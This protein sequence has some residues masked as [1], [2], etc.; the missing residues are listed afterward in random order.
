MPRLPVPGSDDGTWGTVLNDYLS[1]EHNAD[2]T[3]KSTGSLAAKAN[4]STVVHL[5]GSETITGGKTFLVSPT[6]PSPTVG[7][8][9]ANKTYV[10]TT[11]AK[12]SSD[13]IYVEDYG[14]IGDGVTDDSAAITNAITTAVSAA[15]TNGSYYAEVRFQAKTYFVNTPTTGGTTNGS[16]MI[17]LPVILV[18]SQKVTLVLKGVGAA[19]GLYHW[20]QT[21]VQKAGS[22]LRT[23]Y[24]AGST[25]PATGEVSVLGGPTPHYGYGYPSG[26]FSNMLIVV[27]ALT[28]VVP[29]N[30]QICGFDFRGVAEMQ[31]KSAAALAAST[32]SGAPSI[33][34]PTW[35]WGISPP[36][37]QNNAI[38][39]I[40]SFNVEG[41]VSGLRITEHIRCSSLRAINC[42]N[43]ILCD[44]SSG[45][46]H[47]NIITYASVE[48]CT[49][50]IAS[51]SS[52]VKLNIACLDTESPTAATGDHQ[53]NDPGN[54]MV[55]TI[56]INAN[57]Y[58][59]NDLN[60]NILNDATLGVN[61]AS[62]LRII[63]S[64]M[65]PGAVTAPTVPAS[66]T[67]LKNPFW[68]DAA[69]SITG[70]V[71]A[72]KVDGTALGMNGTL[73][74]ATAYVPSGKTIELDY[75]GAAPAWNW[76]IL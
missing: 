60:T 6:V 25:V 34:V 26:L 4:D 38:C 13:A 48:N 64:E 22:V 19:N 32:H 15:Q 46:P 73:A 70:A 3:L 1:V 5:S 27:D 69:V 63:N 49:R 17:P 36:D 43:G 39:D 75:S 33:P 42:F 61:G 35:G 65:I 62:G 7:G 53:I 56:Y 9:V 24:S 2:G 76:T 16:A 74:G 44:G 50:M 55:G 67:A 57:A 14:A 72:V 28:V 40:D 37:I 30:P 11:A 20:N 51:I 47:S 23:T 18:S 8:N 10:D 66:T 58:N 68:R 41:F 12:L 52:R 54:G 31:V 59:P 45:F 71:T 21:N 29:E